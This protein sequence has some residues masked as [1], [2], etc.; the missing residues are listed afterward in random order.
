[1]SVSRYALVCLALSYIVAGCSDA[2]AVAGDVDAGLPD[3]E[4]VRD[5]ALDDKAAD[6][7]SAGPVDEDALSSDVIDDADVE[8]AA[9]PPRPPLDVW[10][11]PNVTSPLAVWLNVT[12]D[13]AASVQ[14]AA[15]RGDTLDWEGE[16][17]APG[18]SHR[19]PVLGLHP[20]TEYDLV[21]SIGANPSSSVTLTH[22]SGTLAPTLPHITVSLLNAERSAPG[23]TVFGLQ[24]REDPIDPSWPLYL[25][26]N[27]QGVP[28][29]SYQDDTLVH[30]G[31]AR[32]IRRLDDGNFVLLLR[33]GVR[34][35]TPAGE[36]VREW[37]DG[38]SLDE[39]YHHDALVLPSGN[40]LL[41]GREEQSLNVPSL[42]GVFDVRGDT[43][44][45]VDATGAVLWSWS[46]F[47]HLDTHL[48]PGPLA[49]NPNQQGGFVDWTH[50][51]GLAF[52]AGTD[53]V[54]LSLRHQ[55]HVVQISRSTGDVM[56][57]FGSGGDYT[58]T[59]GAW[60]YSQHSPELDGPGGLLLYDNGNERPSDEVGGVLPKS[61][62]TSRAVRYVLD[63]SSA[64]AVET[65]SYEVPEFTAFLGGVS[66]LANGNVLV[67]AGGVRGA[68]S[69]GL[70]RLH[71]VTDESPPQ[72]VWTLEVEGLVYRARRL[73]GLTL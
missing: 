47:D 54:W 65:W 23:V 67:C 27:Q 30:E 24:G 29:W 56:A 20:G 43:L 68:T 38:A 12:L 26:V 22:M 41:L 61:E 63:P 14:V 19:V 1:M 8:V 55:N 59:S 52:D 72:L 49:Q 62:R 6:D 69:S 16:A 70:A 17:S 28:V 44:R 7:T 66:R 9:P 58:L 51:N 35:V 15:W 57:R 71:E 45:E 25:A 50:G 37:L 32:D 73:P 4:A 64:T 46:A 48:L 2:P 21:V 39:G 33:E 11:E 31:V 10:L 60:F 36:T 34:V 3:I 18:T 13:A 5:A 53:S 40:L 42:G